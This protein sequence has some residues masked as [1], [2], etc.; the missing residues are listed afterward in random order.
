MQYAYPRTFLS[1]SGG[2]VTDFIPKGLNSMPLMSR[3]CDWT[4][5]RLFHQ[6]STLKR[7]SLGEILPSPK[8]ASNLQKPINDNEDTPV[9]PGALTQKG[10]NFCTAAT[11]PNLFWYRKPFWRFNN[12]SLTVKFSPENEH[13]IVCVRVGCA[14]MLRK[15]G[16]VL[17]LQK[18]DVGITSIYNLESHETKQQIFV[19]S[20]GFTC[21]SIEQ[22]L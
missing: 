3:S 11:D 16:G 14:K 1:D 18:M 21:S 12:S 19:C 20:R 5:L 9:E 22:S 17:L 13:K 6:N 2:D 15:L 10:W 8:H 4:V 7:S